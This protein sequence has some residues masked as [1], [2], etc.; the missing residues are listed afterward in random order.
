MEKVTKIDGGTLEER[1]QEM[2]KFFGL[3]ES[4]SFQELNVDIEEK[5]F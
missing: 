1:L 3:N 2:K 5:E 4:Q